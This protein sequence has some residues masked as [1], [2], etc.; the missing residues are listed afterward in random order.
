MTRGQRRALCLGVELVQFEQ[1]A[2]KLRKIRF[3]FQ[4]QN[5]QSFVHA[6]AP[7]RSAPPAINKKLSNAAKVKRRCAAFAVDICARSSKLADL[8]S[9]R[10][11]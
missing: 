7:I 9:E 8:L 11:N 3:V 10:T 1:G 4:M 5:V 2:D 6:M